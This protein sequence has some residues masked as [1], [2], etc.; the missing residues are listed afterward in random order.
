MKSLEQRSNK[1]VIL[2]PSLNPDHNLVDLAKRLKNEGSEV[3]VV[4]D[5]SEKGC[6]E[7]FRVLESELHCIVLSHLENLGK[8]AALKTGLQHIAEN[9]PDACGVVTAD[10]D[11][12]HRAEDILRIAEALEMCEKQLFL[13]SRDFTGKDIPFKSK[14]GNRITSTVYFMS[15]GKKCADTQTGLRGIPKELYE[16]CIT[17]SG[18]RY[19]YEMNLLLEM[20]KQ[21]I[22]LVP[23]PIST[24]YIENNQ[25]SHFHPFLDSA[26]IYFNIMKYSLS[27]LVSA[28]TDL[29]L[30][31]LFIHQL[32]SDSINGI[33]FATALARILSGTLN[34]MMNKHFVFQSD[35]RHGT[36]AWKYFTLFVCQMTLSW[37]LVSALSI[38]PLHLTLIKILVDGSLFFASYQ[39]QKKYIFKMKGESSKDEKLLLKTV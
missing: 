20:G 18:D 39:I 6:L 4:N 26:R 33:F 3:L 10:A 36:E 17:V 38:L 27:S 25:A 28:A 2:I 7:I 1:A 19:E 30:F 22:P 8:G 29:G 37:L 24:I 16:I 12:Q 5:G 31:T 13:G 21:G 15:I 11:G 35:R 9:F 32:F 14:W 23:V 34:F